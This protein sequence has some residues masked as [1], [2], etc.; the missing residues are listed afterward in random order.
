MPQ[1]CCHS[2]AISTVLSFTTLRKVEQLPVRTRGE[3]GREEGVEDC[4]E[5]RGQLCLEEARGGTN[6]FSRG[7]DSDGGGDDVVHTHGGPA[8]RH[9][10]R[11]HRVQCR[12]LE[13][14]FLAEVVLRVLVHTP[15]ARHLPQVPDPQRTVRAEARHP[16]PIQLPV[17][18]RRHCRTV[19]LCPQLPAPLCPVVEHGDN[20]VAVADEAEVAAATVLKGVDR[21]KRGGGWGCGGIPKVCISV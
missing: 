8:A 21:V 13:L 1:L 6:A 7:D 5:D 9:N 4:G 12:V 14:P 10:E 15:V 19:R 16:T 17:H 18:Q 2:R 20:A 11:K 3:E